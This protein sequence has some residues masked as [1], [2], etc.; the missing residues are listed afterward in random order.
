VVGYPKI[1]VGYLAFHGRLLI[2]RL[3]WRSALTEP[4]ALVLVGH[5]GWTH[6]AC[7]KVS[8]V[9]LSGTLCKV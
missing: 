6:I 8:F 5:W 3:S 7:C 9:R 4:F 2:L 1:A